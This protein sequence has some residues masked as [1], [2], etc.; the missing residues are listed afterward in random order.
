MQP[1]TEPTVAAAQANTKTPTAGEGTGAV[2]NLRL[3]LESTGHSRLAFALLVGVALLLSETWFDFWPRW[4][5]L[6]LG[7]GMVVLGRLLI[8]CVLATQLSIEAQF[9]RVEQPSR[10]TSH[11][12]FWSAIAIVEVRGGHSLLICRHS[13]EATI[14]GPFGKSYLNPPRAKLELAA[15]LAEAAIERQAEGALTT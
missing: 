8:E 13:G 11:I 12:I 7:L 14:I 6:S 9:L 10:S 2:R 3:G 15:E 4:A 5:R 1:N